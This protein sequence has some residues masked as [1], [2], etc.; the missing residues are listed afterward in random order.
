MVMGGGFV[1]TSS[2]QRILFTVDGCGVIGR[3]GE[4]VLRDSEGHPLLV[5]QKKVISENRCSEI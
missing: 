1:V 5:L 4:V 2:C 3:M